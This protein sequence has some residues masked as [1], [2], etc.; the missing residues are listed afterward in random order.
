MEQQFKNV[1]VRDK[2]GHDE[3]RGLTLAVTVFA[4]QR[5]R[6][7]PALEAELGLPKAC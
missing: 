5:R 1:D 4:D 2:R 3:P 6:L 7:V